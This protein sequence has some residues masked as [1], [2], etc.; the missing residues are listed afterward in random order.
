LFEVFSMNKV[1]RRT[2]AMAV[3]IPFL[4]AVAGAAAAFASGVGV[5][6]L[7]VLLEST[8]HARGLSWEMGL[9]II[10][11]DAA[12]GGLPAGLLG[13]LVGRRWVGAAVGA[14]SLGGAAL[15]LFGLGGGAMPVGARV[16]SVAA[17]VL[18]GFAAGFAGA[19]LAELFE[20]RA[21]ARVAERGA[22]D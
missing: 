9:F 1:A 17:G 2:Q 10:P 11:F 6:V 22:A 19:F 14:I 15:W 13:A 5:D 16:G 4:G 7:D 21:A 3:A 12:I 20:R 18:G 8:L